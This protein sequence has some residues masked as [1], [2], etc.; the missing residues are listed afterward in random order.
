MADNITEKGAEA[1]V[2]FH[3]TVN[4][5]LKIENKK[6]STQ[7]IPVNDKLAADNISP[8]MSHKGLVR[9]VNYVYGTGEDPN[10]LY[11]ELLESPTPV[12][13][14]KTDTDKS[15]SVKK[16]PSRNKKGHTN[17]VNGQ[18]APK[19]LSE[20]SGND[21]RINLKAWVAS[22]SDH[23]SSKVLQ[24]GNLADDS[25]E[26]TPPFIIFDGK[27]VQSLKPE[28]LYLFRNVKDNYYEE[29]NRVQVVIDDYSDVVSHGKPSGAPDT[30]TTTKSDHETY[31]NLGDA[32]AD[33]LK[34]GLRPS[35]SPED[36]LSDKYRD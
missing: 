26:H 5:S 18:D 23:G 22:V 30:I 28:K 13:T 8:E 4:N 14:T 3:K 36:V 32:A 29:Q 17:K 24:T 9:V 27:D 34:A 21:S 16:R 11:A 1:T 31:K 35:E 33:H 25:V 7:L 15:Q 6:D 2:K 20:L 10:Q 12:S 19:S